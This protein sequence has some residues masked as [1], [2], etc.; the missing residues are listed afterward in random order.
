L[1]RHDAAGAAG[2][3]A[4]MIDT[5][6]D[7]SSWWDIGRQFPWNPYMS[8]GVE[9]RRVNRVPTKVSIHMSPTRTRRS[10]SSTSTPRTGE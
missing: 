3:R 1:Y 9:V 6:A 10:T 4:I 7:E 2:R 8:T 5:D